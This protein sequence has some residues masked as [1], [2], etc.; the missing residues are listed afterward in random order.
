MPYMISSCLSP[1]TIHLA[2][3]AGP[4]PLKPSPP[5]PSTCSCPPPTSP[6][7]TPPSTSPQPPPGDDDNNAPAP[8]PDD[9]VPPNP[10]ETPTDAGV[11]DIDFQVATLSVRS[12][13]CEGVTATAVD[14]LVQWVAQDMAD[15]HPLGTDLAEKLVAVDTTCVVV[16]S[17]EPGDD[18]V[19]RQ[20]PAT[21]PSCNCAILSGRDRQDACV[22]VMR[23][24]DHE[25]MCRP[26]SIC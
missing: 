2:M 8:P 4:L 12:L 22:L 1:L 15:F 17:R 16:T 3:P 20:A 18:R 13:Q 19:S 6:P 7:G 10:D 11:V 14:A 5:P 25:L 21:V 26:C 9:G 24:Q 23:A